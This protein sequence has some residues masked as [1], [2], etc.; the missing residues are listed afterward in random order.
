MSSAA[1]QYSRYSVA[2]INGNSAGS[3]DI[4]ATPIPFTQTDVVHDVQYTCNIASQYGTATVYD[5]T[6]VITG[7]TPNSV[8][9][10]QPA[11]VTLSGQ[12]F[13][14]NQPQV[15]ESL[16]DAVTVTSYSDTQ[17]V[18]S[19]TPSTTGTGYFTVTAEGFNGQ[20]F[21]ESDGQSQNSPPSPPLNVSCASITNFKENFTNAG[22]D[23]TLYW[24]Y[25]WAST[26]GTQNDLK[27]CT[28]RETVY[29]PGTS[30]PYVWPSPMMS[31]TA[32]PTLIS[33]SPANAGFSDQNGPPSNYSI[34]SVPLLSTLRS[35]SRGTAHATRTT[36]SS[37]LCKTLRS[38]GR[39]FKIRTVSG[40][41][42]LRRMGRPQQLCFHSEDIMRPIGISASVALLWCF[43]LAH[44]QTSQATA[45]Q[46]TTV[47]RALEDYQTIKP[48]LA[49]KEVEKKF[50]YDGGVQFPDQSRFTHRGC[51][52]I[53]VEVT[54]Q[55]APNRGKNLTSPDDV[56]TAVSKLYIDYPARD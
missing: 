29:Y 8:V 47:L 15:T 52:Y 23:G 1:A 6:P 38:Q 18:T 22:A 40:S 24:N 26:T 16:G 19:L 31:Q 9:V 51:D 32:N 11:T 48:G 27:A 14:T 3:V 12:N 30:N 7:V 36:P 56:V 35:V 25:T 43:S 53:K 33:G 28:I 4:T 41:T 45:T 17:I 39:Y 5:P 46:C 34:H 50:K 13:G 2:T 49:R 44:A 54:F 20:G 10:G 55:P 21:V 37:I 42:R